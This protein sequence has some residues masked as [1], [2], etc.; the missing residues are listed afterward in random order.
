MVGEE[1][2]KVGRRWVRK[3]LPGG[4]RVSGGGAGARVGIGKLGMGSGG[5]ARGEAY[6]MP[7]EL[8]AQS[9]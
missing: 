1:R 8:P 9:Q 7:L 4:R 3:A 2:V 5:R 6:F